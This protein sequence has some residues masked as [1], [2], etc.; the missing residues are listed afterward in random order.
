VEN[1]VKNMIKSEG[2][3]AAFSRTH[4]CIKQTIKNI[5]NKVYNIRE[6]AGF[7]F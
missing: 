1:N 4:T 2:N 3:V 5:K 7:S 6:Q